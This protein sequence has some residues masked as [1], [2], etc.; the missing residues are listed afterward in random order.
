V[1]PASC[2]Q[3]R[4]GP[5]DGW[6]RDE[7]SARREAGRGAQLAFVV[8][9]EGVGPTADVVKL[10]GR[11]AQAK[12]ARAQAKDYERQAQAL[13]E[14]SSRMLGVAKGQTRRTD[15]TG[16]N[17]ALKLRDLLLALN[18]GQEN[19]LEPWGF[20]VIIGSAAAPK[21]RAKDKAQ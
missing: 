8:K 10:R 20:T 7:R 11:L 5:R 15:G 3:N 14:Q 17:V 16:L 2:W 1:L 19:A 21:R 18:R 12:P 4:S 6:R 9:L 13:Y